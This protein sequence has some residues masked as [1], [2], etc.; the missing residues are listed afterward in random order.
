MS[1]IL[2]RMLAGAVVIS[3]VSFF[4][5]SASARTQQQQDPKQQD[6]KTQ[7]APKK[8][9][10]QTPPPAKAQAQPQKAAPGAHEAQPQKAAPVAQ[11]EAQPQKAAPVA[12]HEAQPQKA[13]P[14]A[15]HQVQ[16][17]QAAPV[18]QH[19]AQPQQ[20]QPRLSQP[21]QQVLIG[22]QQQRL[23]LYGTQLDQQQRVAPQQ[24][25]Q[26]QQQH[27]TAQCSFQL[28]YVAGLRE[29]QLRIQSD[30]NY[31]YDGDPYFYTP[32]SYRYSRGGHYYETNDY[33]ATVLRAAVNYGYEEGFGT[34]QADR[35]DRWA[36]NYQGSYAYQDANYGFSGFYIQRDEYSYYFREGFR[37][38]YDDGY[39]DRYQYGAYAT[40][41]YA[42]LGSVLSVILNLQRLQ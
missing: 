28:Q 39:Y 36:S 20:A 2:N 5:A 9:Q 23:V 3:A 17:Q 6:P 38:G 4:G 29:Q 13:A 8:P 33:G 16:P 11:H 21:Q 40:G 42:V 35:Q 25:V 22:Q 41:K 7:E 26:L 15:Q 12:Q 18:A 10:A 1:R 27:R 14:V 30:G 37:R 31:N 32:S 34:G 24:E 19:Q